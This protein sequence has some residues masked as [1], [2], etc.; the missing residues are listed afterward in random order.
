[1]YHSKS[2]KKKKKKGSTTKRDTLKMKP[3]KQGG[4]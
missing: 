1:M 3:K 2:I 4:Y